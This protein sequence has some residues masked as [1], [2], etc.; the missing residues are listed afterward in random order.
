M[1]SVLSHHW[2]WRGV[3]EEYREFLPVS[4]D[5]PVVTL[6]EGGTPLIESRAIGPSLPGRI[7]LLLKYEGVNPTGSFKD[8]GM[9]MAIT[10]AKEEGDEA[11][12]TLFHEIAE[13]EEKHHERYVKLADRL[14]QGNLLS[15]Q[16]EETEWKCLNCGYI[17]KGSEA[18]HVCPVCK[19]PQGWYMQIGFVR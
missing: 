9:T 16:S 5:T 6:L 14:E 12:A 3:I 13:V 8:R 4:E 7:R 15:G 10:K 18:P 2:P 11:A 17:H 1:P 19:K